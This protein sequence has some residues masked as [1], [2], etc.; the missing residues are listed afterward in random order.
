LHVSAVQVLVGFCPDI[1]DD[2]R[3]S[4]SEL[5]LNG[6]DPGVV[7]QL[8]DGPGAEEVH[9]AH[10]GREHGETVALQVKLSQSG[11]L[12]DLLWN[13][14]QFVVSY[15]QDSKIFQLFNVWTKLLEI[16]VTEIHGSEG[17]H[18][19]E[20]TWETVVAEIV[21]REIENLN[22]REGAEASGQLVE[23]VH[24][25][26]EDPELWHPR[27]RDGN[28]LQAV[29]EQVEDLHVLQVGNGRGNLG[30]LVVG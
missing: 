16:V 10:G 11:D 3:D 15:R 17:L 14:D 29:V 9:A 23:S 18:D 30:D 2:M 26:V 28:L 19:E 25:E 27:E 8:E 13:I 20:V 12:A 6:W 21:V 1:F 22:D 7:V 5:I 24:A 4:Q